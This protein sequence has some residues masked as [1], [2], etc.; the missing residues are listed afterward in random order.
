MVV[1]SLNHTLFLALNA[2]SEPPQ[3]LVI[4]AIL[5]AK[6]LILLVPLHIALV[7]S[8]GTRAMRFMAITSVLALLAALAANQIIGLGAYTPRPFVVGIG[9]TLIDHRPSFSFPS[10]HG[11]VFFTYAITLGL[12]GVRRLAWAT[13]GL[14]LL[15]AWSRIYLGVHFPFDMIGAAVVSALASFSSLQIML[16]SGAGVFSRLDGWALRLLPLRG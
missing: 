11:T 4:F 5:I 2:S 7:W 6:Y 9:N 10:N 16:R 3:A 13:A 15:V 12:F 8:G 1:D 14:G